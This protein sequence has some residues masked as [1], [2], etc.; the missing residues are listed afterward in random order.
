M[1]KHYML[2]GLTK[3]S[4]AQLHSIKRLT[5]QRR[6]IEDMLWSVT[7][8]KAGMASANYDIEHVVEVKGTT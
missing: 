7:Q 8:G 5:T 1:A 2:Q 4:K 3:S 6:D